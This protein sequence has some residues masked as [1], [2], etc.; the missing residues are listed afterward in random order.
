[1]NSSHGSMRFDSWFNKSL[2]LCEQ[3][4]RSGVMC[5]RMRER[6]R[7]SL[8]WILPTATLEIN[9]SMSPISLNSCSISARRLLFSV[10]SAT[11]SMRRLICS[12]CFSGITIQRFSKRSPI[13][14]FVPL[15][16]SNSVFPP[17]FSG[18][19]NS[20]LRM[21]KRSSQTYFS[22][23]MRWIWV[24]CPSLSCWVSPK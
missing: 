14:V 6:T 4:S 1:M 15:I 21:V 24:M 16:T 18:A 9:L 23:S 10:K 5:S 7:N 8:G 11:A 17:S 22:S 19:I 12:G 2:S 20:R 13:G 3:A